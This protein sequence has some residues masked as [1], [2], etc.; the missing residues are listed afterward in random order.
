MPL[1]FRSIRNNDPKNSHQI[2]LK[3]GNTLAFILS[4]TISL[5]FAHIQNPFFAHFGPV[6]FWPFS[7]PKP[8]YNSGHSPCFVHNNKS[9]KVTRRM[10]EKA[11]ETDCGNTFASVLF[12]TAND[13]WMCRY[14][15]SAH[16][17][18]SFL[19]LNGKVFFLQLAIY[20]YAIILLYAR[21]VG[22]GDMEWKRYRAFRSRN[23]G[24]DNKKANNN[25]HTTTDA[26]RHKHTQ[27]KKHA[28]LN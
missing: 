20:T 24:R 23:D 19:F 13:K 6:L 3:K 9:I 2:T 25:T 8:F 4:L 27:H 10:N 17:F 22:E 1:I 7:L 26:N 14:F 16:S 12:Y 18:A 11:I 21:K 28:S 5:Y 15:F